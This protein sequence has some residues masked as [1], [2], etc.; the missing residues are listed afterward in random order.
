LRSHPDGLWSSPTNPRAGGA[1]RLATLL[2]L[3]SLWKPTVENE[4]APSLENIP[5]PA[6]PLQQERFYASRPPSV[7]TGPLLDE[8][9]TP[10]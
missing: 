9:S 8:F 4:P 6:A 10:L 2:N 1:L 5:S 7:V 3:T